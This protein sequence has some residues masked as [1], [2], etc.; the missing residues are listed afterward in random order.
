MIV[1]G[2]PS[3][4]NLEIG[5]REAAHEL[6]ARVQHAHGDLHVVD[7][8]SERRRRL[9]ILC[10]A[11]LTADLKVGTDGSRRDELLRLLRLAARGDRPYRLDLI[12]AHAVEHVV[13]VHDRVA[14]RNDQ[15]ELVAHLVGL[16]RRV[17]L[18]R[19]EL[20]G[21]RRVPEAGLADARSDRACSA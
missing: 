3:S 14:V 10:P 15:L 1:W 13:Q 8:G 9:L 18:D 20:V 17:V 12:V 21:S 5:L 4:K 6:P 11:P 19:A 16:V 2:W 7:L